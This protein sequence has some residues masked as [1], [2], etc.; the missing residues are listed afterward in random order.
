MYI[1]INLFIKRFL[2]IMSTLNIKDINKEK[3]SIIY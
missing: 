3:K 1:K 2:F